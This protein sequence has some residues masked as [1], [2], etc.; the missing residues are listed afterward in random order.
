MT[1]EEKLVA[2]QREHRALLSEVEEL[3]AQKKPLDN[4]LRTLNSRLHRLGQRIYDLKHDGNTPEVTDHALVRY[5]ERVK[6]VDIKELKVEV[7]QH[8]QAHKVGNV[9]V[10]V[11]SDPVEAT[12]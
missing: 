3:R 2:A 9:I 11:N 6:G 8:K 7:A 5:L 12:T 10:T 1:R 4:R